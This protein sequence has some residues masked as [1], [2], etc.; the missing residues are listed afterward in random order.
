MTDI[1]LA[2]S[3][4]SKSGSATSCG[5]AL[6]VDIGGTKI[7]AG[8]VTS[9]GEV[10]R[11]ERWPMPK[12]VDE[13]ATTDIVNALVDSLLRDYPQVGEIGIGCAGYVEWPSGI[14]RYA[15]NSSYRGY[16]IRD[17][18]A[19]RTGLRTVIDNDGNVAA[20]AEYCVGAAMGH[21]IAVMLT[22]GTGIGGGACLDGQ[23]FRGS[24]G[25]GLEIGHVI[26]DPGGPRCGCGN[27]GCLEARVSG[28]ALAQRAKEVAA[29]NGGKRLI[30][31][32]GDVEKIT[33]E[34][35][36]AAAGQGDKAAL[37]LFNEMGFWLGTGVACLVTLFDPTVV[38]LGGGMMAAGELLLRPTRESL[39]EH[40]YALASRKLPFVYPAKTGPQAVVVGAALM[41]L[42]GE[43][44]SR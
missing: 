38:V 7:S 31:L 41:A 1:S 44:F 18:L 27:D 34:V 29:T 22:A 10:L 40:V 24:S 6:G 33:G 37:D 20:W 36:F 5:L 21:R 39:S 9:S 35:V 11:Y 25:L 43:V 26:V 14:V 4:P 19:N 8:V 3:S 28:T 15:A 12:I 42:H 32:A 30:E 16:M 13:R 23:L 17:H 2:R